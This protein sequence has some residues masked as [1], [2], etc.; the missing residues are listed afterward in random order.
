MVDPCDGNCL[1]HAIS[2]QTTIPVRALRKIVWN[3]LQDPRYRDA[4][5]EPP[6]DVNFSWVGPFGD[7]VPYA[8]SRALGTTIFIV[9]DGV[10]YFIHPD[11]GRTASPLYLFLHAGHYS[12]LIP[13]EPLLRW[14]DAFYDSD[15]EDDTT[16]VR[17]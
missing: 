1:F 8:L 2:A 3:E 7:I 4:I 15:A 12:I 9:S 11:A 16:G 6:R 13:K 5:P 10:G 14:E 17:R